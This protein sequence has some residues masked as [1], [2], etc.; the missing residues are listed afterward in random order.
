[1]GVSPA[2][3]SVHQACAAPMEA[4]GV[5][6]PGT[7]CELPGGCWELDLD[8]LEKQPV[9]L[10]T[11]ISLQPLEMIL[12]NQ[13]AC[14]YFLRFISIYMYVCCLCVYISH[15]CA[16]L[17]RPEEGVGFPGDTHL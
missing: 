3:V 8:L 14:G 1:M 13:S 17:P 9:L 6:S 4:R 2:C 7:D 12:L 10:A 5:G 11:E 16:C 15:A